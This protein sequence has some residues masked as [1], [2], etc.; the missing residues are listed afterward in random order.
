[1]LVAFFLIMV[2]PAAKAPDYLDEEFEDGKGGKVA[3]SEMVRTGLAKTYARSKGVS[4][5]TSTFQELDETSFVHLVES[6][7]EF[8][9]GYDGLD[10]DHRKTDVAWEVASAL[11]WFCVRRLAEDEDDKDEVTAE[12]AR[13]FTTNGVCCAPVESLHTTP[14]VI[15]L[16][17]DWIPVR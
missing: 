9:D 4:W 14:P 15:G 5:T 7:V 3:L 11:K 12:D 6:A 16:V 1:V 8:G 2:A 13:V 10:K 17:L